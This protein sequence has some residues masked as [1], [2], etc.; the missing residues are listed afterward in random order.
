MQK[1][2]SNIHKIDY[3]LVR[4]PAMM[5]LI[6]LAVACGGS[7]QFKIEGN[8]ADGKSMTVRY[9]YYDA[10]G[11]RLLSGMTVSKEGKFEIGGSVTRPSLLEITDNNYVPLAIVPVTDGD[12]LKVDIKSS[13]G[14]GFSVSG[15]ELAQ[16]WSDFFN[17]AGYGPDAV[18][19]AAAKFGTEYPSL[20]TS[21]ASLE[22]LRHKTPSGNTL[23]LVTYISSSDSAMVFDMKAKDL[24]MLIMTDYPPGDDYPQKDS[25]RDVRR[26]RG[27]SGMSMIE[28]SAYSDI[29]RWSREEKRDTVSWKRGY[30]PGGIAAPGLEGLQ[31][32]SLPVYILTDNSGKV[33]Y[34]GNSIAG[35]Q[36]KLN[37]L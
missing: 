18:Y 24:N 36:S 4:L 30:A 6:L 29:D 15:S 34:I 21:L 7:S 37:S 35:L 28:L 32:A 17:T 14:G 12:E 11:N 5:A 27:S 2:K 25:L 10:A 3:M 16:K 33:L 20:Q 22:G 31:I 23:S 8:L 26:L 13:S 1:T 9:V 19:E